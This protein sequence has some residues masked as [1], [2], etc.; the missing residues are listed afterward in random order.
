MDDFIHR[1]GRNASGFSWEPFF[2][3]S[4]LENMTFKK[5]LSHEVTKIHKIFFR[6]CAL[7]TLWFFLL[8]PLP[9]HAAT[10]EP[11]RARNGMVASVSEIAS[12]VG[13]EILKKGGNAV[14]AAV[15]VGLALA[16]TWPEAGN[17]GGGGFMLLRLKD[18]TTEVIDY[19]ERAPLGATRDMYLDSKGNV[20]P[21]ASTVGYK[22]IAVPGTVAGFAL[23]LKRHG[24]LQWKE[25]AEPAYRLAAEGFVV[26]DNMAKR[27]KNQQELISKFPESKRIFLRDGKYYQEGDRLTQPEL[28][29]TLQRLIQNGPREF[30][31]G[32]TAKLISD[33]I[34][35]NGG[36]LSL[37]D[38][39]EYEPTI[40]K[41][42][43][44][45]Y[46]GYQIVTMPPPSSGGPSVLEMLNVLERFNVS[47]LGQN[48]SEELHLLVETMRRAYADRAEFMGDP[49]F[50]T[51][52][53]E[54]LISKEYAAR[55]AAGIDLRKAT[56]SS[57]I[58]PR[59]ALSSESE[60]TTHFS[61]IDH[62]D[63]I[64]V[65]TYTLDAL[66]GSGVTIRG[67]GV[68]M[69][70]EMD[71]FTAKPGAANMWGLVQSDANAIAP[72]KRPVSS[73]TPTIILK[74]EKPYF[75]IGSPGGGTIPNT[76]M[77]V[78]VNIIDYKMNLQQAI[79]SPRFHH[80]WMP[81]EIQYEPMS[82][83]ADTRKAMEAM[84]HKFSEDP[85]FLGD[86]QGIMIEPETGMLLGGCDPRRGGLTAI[87]Y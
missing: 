34:Q 74:D 66:F 20:I 84:G 76:V 21:D 70:D 8:V 71:D 52:P 14:D 47:G 26:N 78:I 19:R 40:R 9:D 56:S 55:V 11:A 68:L 82:L 63:N 22:A 48:S 18:G 85:Y 73:M 54:K 16:V 23:A 81:D 42:L 35:A 67:T 41:P 6:I 30:Y 28:A 3:G 83:N 64:V 32:K 4:F 37:Q 51:F 49:D 53:L 15:A 24:K 5:P 59:T 62:D 25:I 80:Q 13:V 77:Q 72:R 75:A 45:T 17:L 79:E 33:E 58:H 57:D 43:F 46:R 31:E 65:N 10:R 38:L 69:N 87:G 27:I 61:V 12:T 39:K 44:G 50:A 60:H 29:E 1:C 7:L 36:I 2:V 86:V